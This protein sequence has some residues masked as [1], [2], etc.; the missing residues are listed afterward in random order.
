M[1]NDDETNPDLADY[2]GY[3][4]LEA[5]FGKADSFVLTSNL[6]LAEQG[7]SFQA[8]VTY[9]ISKLLVENLDLYFMVQYSN[10]LAESLL[11]YRERVE[12]VRIGFA[13]IR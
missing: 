9:P 5:K 12:A 10:S 3:L 6:R 4:E 13:I 2:R 8:D 1:G 7:P 11:N